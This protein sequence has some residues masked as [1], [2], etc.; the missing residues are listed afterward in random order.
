MVHWVE[1]LVMGSRVLEGKV[2]CHL[3]SIGNVSPL[4]IVK[5]QLG[6]VPVGD[7]RSIYNM[8]IR[9]SIIHLC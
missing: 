6:L 3:P 9:E 1:M 2:S 5:L 8:G 4:E 7:G